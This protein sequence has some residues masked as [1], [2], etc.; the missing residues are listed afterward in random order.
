MIACISVI[1]KYWICVL[2]HHL[3]EK[4]WCV[5]VRCRQTTALLL[6][7]TGS[8]GFMLILQWQNQKMIVR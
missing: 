7:Q 5:W 1:T 8:R 3:A 2:L 6:Y 4:M